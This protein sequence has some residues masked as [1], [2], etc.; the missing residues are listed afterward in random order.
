M[1]KELTFKIYRLEL[2]TGKIGETNKEYTSTVDAREECDFLNGMTATMKNVE[3]IKYFYFY[4]FYSD[5][6]AFNSQEDLRDLALKKLERWNDELNKMKALYMVA[7]KSL[8]QSGLQ[9]KE[10]AV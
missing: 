9:N 5:F 6:K 7:I 1:E 10:E 2:A 8:L 3:N 4:S